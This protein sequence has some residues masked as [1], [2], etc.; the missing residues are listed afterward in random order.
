MTNRWVQAQTSSRL[1]STE[2]PKCILV[3]G[4]SLP[5]GC[6]LHDDKD[7]LFTAVSPHLE[8]SLE[9]VGPPS[10]VTEEMNDL[11]K[12]FCLRSRD[13][14][15]LGFL[16]LLGWRRVELILLP[17]PNTTVCCRHI[18]AETEPQCQESREPGRAVIHSHSAVGGLRAGENLATELKLGQ[19]IEGVTVIYSPFGLLLL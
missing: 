11:Q 18:F 5:Q 13:P 9:H 3:D 17:P 10:I 7:S 6:T 12:Y 8:E 1:G 15:W 2:D 14:N 19:K 4:L 16:P